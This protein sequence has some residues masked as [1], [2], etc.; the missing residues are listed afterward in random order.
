MPLPKCHSEGRTA[1][2]DE[3]S[4]S[5]GVRPEKKRQKLITHCIT[6]KLANCD[7]SQIK[8]HYT[9]VDITGWRKNTKFSPTNF[10]IHNG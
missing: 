6:T 2:M 5:F 3:L 8:L 9:N 7:Q 4:W 10:Q 1:V